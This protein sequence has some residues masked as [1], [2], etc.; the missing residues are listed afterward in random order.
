MR[1]TVLFGV[2]GFTALA[3]LA[4][5]VNAGLQYL[6][7][8]SSPEVPVG[9]PPAATP[10]AR[11][12]ATLFYGA[13]DGVSLAPVRVDVPLAEGAVA[14]G[15]QIVLALLQPPP[16]PYLAVIPAGTTLRALYLT[17]G[18][19]A[20][21]DLSAEV[22]TKHPGGTQAELLTVYAIVNAVTTNLRGVRRV[23]LLID[24]READTVAGH[25]DVRRPLE[26]DASLVRQES[27]PAVQ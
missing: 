24:G 15:S 21:V 16:A 26:L 18:G 6:G 14:Q 5:G 9:P 27:P 10:T 13:P 11:I 4:W 3:L 20:F 22:S 12:A 23:Q 25:V 1:R 2:A 19:D 7:R 8:T 17:A